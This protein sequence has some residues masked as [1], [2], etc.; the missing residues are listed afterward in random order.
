MGEALI[1][2]DAVQL[3]PPGG[4]GAPAVAVRPE[5]VPPIAANV[6]EDEVK[7]TDTPTEEPP[8]VTVAEVLSHEASAGV[9]VASVMPTAAN[10]IKKAIASG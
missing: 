7:L 8:W 9:I 1:E 5:L 3:P 2:T 10:N 6:S 4:L